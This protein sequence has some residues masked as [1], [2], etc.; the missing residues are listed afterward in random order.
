MRHMSERTIL[1]GRARMLTKLAPRRVPK[2]CTP[3]ILVA[4]QGELERVAA[5]CGEVKRL[6]LIM[7]VVVQFEGSGFCDLLHAAGKRRST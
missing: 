1:G 5:V 2:A 6:L 7:R 3:L 4:Y